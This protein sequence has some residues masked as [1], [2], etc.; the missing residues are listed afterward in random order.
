MK[1]NVRTARDELLQ[2]FTTF[3]G[4]V[5]AEAEA[6]AAKASEADKLAEKWGEAVQRKIACQI[7]DRSY[8]YLAERIE[9]GD[10][11]CAPDGRVLVRSIADYLYR[12]APKPKQKERS[13]WH[14]DPRRAA[15]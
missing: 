13:R 2:A 5:V 1:S 8:N 7:M 6:P 11:A 12:G 14:I 9:S 3:V 10:I 15:Q 4:A